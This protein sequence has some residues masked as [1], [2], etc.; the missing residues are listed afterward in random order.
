MSEKI[1]I[2]LVEDSDQLRTRLRDILVR[3]G[4]DVQAESNIGGLEDALM[5]STPDLTILD[6][7]LPRYHF[8]RPEDLGFE[9]QDLLGESG[10]TVLGMSAFHRP[11]RGPAEELEYFGD[12]FIQKG[13][14]TEEFLVKVRQMLQGVDGGA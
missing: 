1:Q 11:V 8:S 7:R 4:Y 12:D 9:A 3:A 5:V 13:F 10:V 6:F 2:L 14:S